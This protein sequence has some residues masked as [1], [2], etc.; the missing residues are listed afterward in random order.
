[1]GDKIL[2]EAFDK[3]K[4]I[5]ESDD[6]FCVNEAP[7]EAE[8]GQFHEMESQLENLRDG[9]QELEEIQNEFFETRERLVDAIRAYYPSQLPYWESYGLAHLAIIFGS[10]QYAS[11]DESIDTLIDKMRK[12]YK[13]TK[14]HMGG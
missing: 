10:D 2:T 7:A 4:A 3:I 1:M 5:E 9:I 13:A 8:I 12:D 14:E 11:A 6:P